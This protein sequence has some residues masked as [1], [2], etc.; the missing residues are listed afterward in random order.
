M[1]ENDYILV[2]GKRRHKTVGILRVNDDLADG[3]VALS[4]DARDNAS[5]LTMDFCIVKIA[6]TA[7]LNKV[8]LA[9]E[10][11][12][13]APRLGGDIVER[14]VR[15][16]FNE[17]RTANGGCSRPIHVGD[18]LPVPYSGM[19][20]R[21]VVMGVTAAGAS[22]EYGV[23]E[24]S[25]ELV[26]SDE[27]VQPSKDAGTIRYSDIGGLNQQLGVI[28]E[29]IELPL[30]MPKLF[31]TLGV[32]PPKGVLMSGSPGC[33]KTLIARAMASEANV[34]FFDCNGGG[35]I[36]K[37][38]AETEGNIRK[39]FEDCSAHAPA[40]LFIDEVDAVAANRDKA[41]SAASVAAT[42]ALLTQ[43]DGIKSAARVMV[44]A[45]TNLPNSLDPAVRRAGRFD[46]EVVIPV[47]DRTGR[48]EI[49]QIFIKRRG[50]KIL[51]PAN[52]DKP[53]E[54]PDAVDI[55]RLADET[56]G[57]TGA[58]L[59]SLCTKAA[60]NAM[61][62]R[63]AL[64][65]DL[66]SK[67]ID[68]ADLDRHY[69][70]MS[71]FMA[72]MLHITPS[73]MRDVAIQKPNVTFA[74]IGGLENVKQ[75]LREMI[76]MPVRFGDMFEDMGITP[77]KGA[78]LYGPPG[79]GKT[80][81][82][83]A[84]ANECGCNFISIKGPQLLSKWVGESEENVRDIF[85]K[86]RNSSPCVIFFD[87]LDSVAMKRGR[88][89]GQG[90]GD[91][92]VNQLLTEM[93]GVQ[94]RK[95]VFV[96]GASNF[97]DSVDPAVLRTGRMDQFIYI[98]LPE[99][100]ADCEKILWACLRKTPLESE[101]INMAAVAE[102]CFK[103]GL[104]PADIAG[105]CKRAA[106][107]AVITHLADNGIGFAPD[108]S[109]LKTTEAAAAA[110]S[111]AD[112]A[113]VG[114]V[115]A[116]ATSGGAPLAASHS[117]EEKQIASIGKPRPVSATLFESAASQTFPSVSEVDRARYEAE[118]AKFKVQLTTDIGAGEYSGHFV[119]A[120]PEKLK[121]Q[122]YGRIEKVDAEDEE[123]EDRPPTPPPPTA[124]DDAAPRKPVGPITS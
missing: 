49:L 81:M 33:G 74:D 43:M 85:S 42:S 35:L 97:I 17:F 38:P 22:V 2:T 123:D 82:A 110:A 95:N 124:S 27:R 94:E 98:G 113:A 84:I 78:F 104:S 72:A 80:L 31:S 34:Y 91:S 61:T 30:R 54:T 13:G 122:P 116:D 120:D 12:E 117:A 50:L 51:R 1:F 36:G 101:A 65:V 109:K 14:V 58:D 7:S 112:G 40:I 115:A 59:A 60:L 19:D 56:H 96:I 11:R 77:P 70:L 53:E 24:A 18:V 64:D 8:D 6:D 37:N 46:T 71:D 20:L 108:G 107:D 4:D 118:R 105:L 10:E 52:P 39:V 75:E 28:R 76:E 66:E 68:V 25:T 87:E 3:V 90:P 45:A 121:Y 47:P 5:V 119:V 86:A 102:W 21:F 92:V 32:K 48:K 41:G 111:A 29:T 55:D 99:S 44:L 23:V 103:R 9:L 114:G 89:D 26:L 79:C 106:K 67:E 69:V 83:K 88:S 15:P 93:D 16:W 57:Y 62:E 73:G 100:A 63:V